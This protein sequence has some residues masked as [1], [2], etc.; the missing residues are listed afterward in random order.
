V[1][2]DA[3]FETADMLRRSLDLDEPVAGS[4]LSTINGCVTTAARVAMHNAMQIGGAASVRQS[5][6]VLKNK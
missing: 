4:L 3:A 6:P 1:S 2:L 5:S